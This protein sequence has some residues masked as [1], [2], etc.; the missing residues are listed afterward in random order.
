MYKCI[1]KPLKKYKN[2]TIRFKLPIENDEI[3]SNEKKND[4]LFVDRVHMTDL[5]YSMLAKLIFNY[6]K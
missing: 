2:P 3:L 1:C 5:G 6:I 4:W